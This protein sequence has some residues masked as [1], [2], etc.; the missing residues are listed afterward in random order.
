MPPA[1]MS[2]F[3]VVD[4]SSTGIANVACWHE[5]DVQH[6]L[7]LGLL[8]AALPTLR[9]ECWFTSTFQTLLPVV[10]NVGT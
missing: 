6:P 2:H 7:E 9:P 3:D 4:G 10:L 1:A 8:T 5:A